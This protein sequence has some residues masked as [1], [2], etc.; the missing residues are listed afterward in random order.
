MYWLYKC[1]SFWYNEPLAKLTTSM[2]LIEKKLNSEELILELI[3]YK[4]SDI[5]KFEEILITKIIEADN[6]NVMIAQKLIDWYVSDDSFL[7]FRA[8]LISLWK[9]IFENTIKNPDYLNDSL[10]K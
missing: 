5:V 7:Y 9:D 10:N 4:E 2:E 8:W 3:Q 6:Y 1:F